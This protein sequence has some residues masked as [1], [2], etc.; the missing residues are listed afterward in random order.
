VRAP[1]RVTFVVPAYN[2]GRFLGPALDSLLAQDFD[3]LELIVIDDC[4]TDDTA[5]VMARYRHEPRVRGLR[6]TKNAGHIRTYNEG[7]AIAR[8]E[9]MGLLSADDICLR[10]D[11]VARQVALFDAKPELGF[12]YSP[13]AYVDIEGRLLD[14][15]RRY[16][17]DSIHDGLAEFADLV[18]SNYVPASGTL[19][20]AACH[21]AIGYYDERL[22]HAGDWDLWLRLAAHY[23]VGYVTDPLYGWRLHRGNMHEL[24]IDP[25]QA[26]DDH[27]LVLQKAFEALP[28]SAPQEVKQLQRPAQAQVALRAIDSE[29]RSGRRSAGWQRAWQ[30][31]RSHPELL[32]RG[33][34]HVSLAKLA[35][36]SVVRPPR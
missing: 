10:T 19:V 12:V 17:T 32:R 9:F 35:A 28:S 21:R 22:P 27:L 29:R 8:G 13:L 18:F 31:A 30:A 25:V 4:S 24:R 16:P 7:L 15:V 33:A 6:H 2:Y 23:P 3:S 20:R 11:A 34:F 36:T 1:P 26:H 5:E 14:V